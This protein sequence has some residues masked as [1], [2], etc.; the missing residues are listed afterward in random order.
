[1]AEELVRV[2]HVEADAVVADKK[3]F[4]A[5]DVLAANLNRRVSLGTGELP[6]VADEIAQQDSHEA[7]VGGDPQVR[8]DVDRHVPGGAGRNDLLDDLRRHRA[9]V[10]LLTVDVTTG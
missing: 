8:G 3:P 1:G 10:H 4:L 5:A 6:G 2:Q 7:N 9:H